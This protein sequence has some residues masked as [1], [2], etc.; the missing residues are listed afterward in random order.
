MAS[1]ESRSPARSRV[2][3]APRMAVRGVRSSWETAVRRVSFCSSKAASRR[4]ASR[5]AM[6][7]SVMS[8]YT[9]ASSWAR[10]C[11]RRQAR[12]RHGARRAPIAGEHAVGAAKW[13]ER[14][15]ATLVLSEDAVAVRG[16]EAGLPEIR[17]IAVLG[18]VSQAGLDLWALA[19]PGAADAV[20]LDVGGGWDLPCPGKPC[21]WFHFRHQPPHLRTADGAYRRLPNEGRSLFRSPHALLIGSNR[22]E[23]PSGSGRGSSPHSGGAS[24]NP[25]PG[26][27]PTGAG[28]VGPAIRLP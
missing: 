20:V 6:V 25:A 4:A 2:S 14:L 15:V 17:G 22:A 18:G 9:L 5:W 12:L 27:G 16:M 11:R 21:P 28:G 1:S 23:S 8:T 26:R 10:R 13:F 19:D 24:G 3:E 7:W